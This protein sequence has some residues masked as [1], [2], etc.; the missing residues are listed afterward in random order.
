MNVNLNINTPAYSVTSQ[1]K[2]RTLK[3]KNYEIH[4]EAA[5]RDLNAGH[6]ERIMEFIKNSIM[7]LDMVKKIF[8]LLTQLESKYR[9]FVGTELRLA[10][11]E[12]CQRYSPEMRFHLALLFGEEAPLFLIKNASKV[13]V[14]SSEDRLR[15]FQNIL[16]KNGRKVLVHFTLGHLLSFFNLEERHQITALECLMKHLKPVLPHSENWNDLMLWDFK[17]RSLEAQLALILKSKDIFLCYQFIFAHNI[18]DAEVLSE[19]HR[20]E[21][22]TILGELKSIQNAVQEFLS[23]EEN[24]NES[25][26]KQIMD[27]LP[28]EESRWLAVRLMSSGLE[29]SGGCGVDKI[30]RYFALVDISDQEK[31]FEVVRGIIRSIPQY[32]PELRSRIWDTLAVNLDDLNLN[33]ESRLWVLKKII[34]NSLDSIGHDLFTMVA[35]SKEQYEIAIVLIKVDVEFF[36]LNLSSFSLLSSEQLVQL[37]TESANYISCLEMLFPLFEFLERDSLKLEGKVKSK[38]FEMFRAIRVKLNVKACPKN[39]FLFIDSIKRISSGEKLKTVHYFLAQSDAFL[40]HEF[41]AV[42]DQLEMAAVH[43]SLVIDELLNVVP[44]SCIEYVKLT[45]MQRCKAAISAL[46]L[47]PF[48]LFNQF[49]ERGFKIIGVNYQYD[50]A[51]RLIQGYENLADDADEFFGSYFLFLPYLEGLTE[52]HFLFLAKMV[53]NHK[54]EHVFQQ[55]VEHVLGCEKFGMM[56]TFALNL[57][58]A[59]KQIAPQWVSV[60]FNS[61]I[62]NSYANSKTRESIDNRFKEMDELLEDE[63]KI[64]FIRDIASRSKIQC[65]QA[66]GVLGR[67][68][69]KDK[70]SFREL[71]FHI[72]QM[73]PSEFAVHF[74]ELHV[75]DEA[76]RVEIAMKVAETNPSTLCTYIDNF[77]IN[78]RR[79]LIDLGY[80][81]YKQ[82]R[83][84]ASCYLEHLQLDLMEELDQTEIMEVMELSG[85]LLEKALQKKFHEVQQPEL[86]ELIG[87]KISQKNGDPRQDY[88][89]HWAARLLEKAACKQQEKQ[90][91]NKAISLRCELAVMP[92]ICET[93]PLNELENHLKQPFIL[94][95]PNGALNFGA[96]FQYMGANTLKGGCFYTQRHYH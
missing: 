96:S 74:K 30:I 34:A 82:D 32:T 22:A 55:F 61:I 73:Y 66:M 80:C 62:F 47:A 29:A 13:N 71:L 59:V 25:D 42:L 37:I 28:N 20:K 31:C 40:K 57:L 43:R 95:G 86:L 23:V 18:A 87:R 52:E 4:F 11:V 78:D 10:L 56:A 2:S 21:L 90:N 54:N 92:L 39:F 91:Y 53:I 38:L 33:L 49:K 88:E 19:P 3:E 14:E 67:L 64:K 85:S 76:L 41:C 35:T 15:I 48:S 46:S 75:F 63:D 69:F 44:I 12:S 7:T 68:T 84:L 1:A 93:N 36:L 5:L 24:D 58:E 65:L 27:A 94:E 77:D 72:F 70:K 89:K 51:S 79:R 9:F 45:P 81:I 50:F 83:H 17:D 60:A 26:F 16:E 6:P 8:F